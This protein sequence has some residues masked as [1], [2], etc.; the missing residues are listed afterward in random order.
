MLHV[1]LEKQDYMTKKCW[2][3]VGG[4]FPRVEH[5]NSLSDTKW[6]ALKTYIQIKLY[7]PSRLY[8][9]I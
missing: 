9:R 8:L 4:V 6:S 3:C 7:K 5:T 1:T 2:E